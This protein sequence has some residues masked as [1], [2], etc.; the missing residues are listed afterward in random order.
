MGKMTNIRYSIEKSDP[1]AKVM[2]LPRLGPDD[3]FSFKCSEC[4]KCC[5]NREDIILTPL[6]LF[7]MSKHLNLSNAE[8]INQYCD[9][10][11]GDSSR[12]PILRLRPREYRK[13]CPLNNKG[14]CIVH[15]V[16]PIVCALF[17]LARFTSKET[18][19]FQYALQPVECG[20]RSESHTVRE[21]LESFNIVAEESLSKL[22]HERMF[23]II[24]K[25]DQIMQLIGEPEGDAFE[26]FYTLLFNLMYVGYDNG[27]EYLPQFTENFDCISEFLDKALNAA[28]EDKDEAIG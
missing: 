28:Q 1:R 6:D 26:A 9:Y 12:L 25:T 2:D 11:V 21:W 16:K 20:S 13:T 15:K 22:W 10:Y 3:S 23:E 5:R 24:G 17:P 19:N 27:K 8:F 14:L 4:G 18:E 7:K